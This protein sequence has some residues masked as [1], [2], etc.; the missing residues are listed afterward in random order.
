LIQQP[1]L[2]GMTSHCI[3]IGRSCQSKS[4]MISQAQPIK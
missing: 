4:E 2:F 1:H 3:L